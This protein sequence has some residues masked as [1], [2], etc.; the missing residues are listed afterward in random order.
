[1]TLTLNVVRINPNTIEEVKIEDV[2]S[3]AVDDTNI[4]INYNDNTQEVIL[5]RANDGEHVNE[6]S[7]LNVFVTRVGMKIGKELGEP[8]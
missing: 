7:G 4:F 1:M 3:F 8:K 6:W 5:L 2:A